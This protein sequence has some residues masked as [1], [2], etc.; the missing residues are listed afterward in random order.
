MGLDL[1]STA[2][3]GT[4]PPPPAQRRFFLNSLSTFF[5]DFPWEGRKVKGADAATLGNLNLPEKTTDPDLR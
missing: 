5:G 2:A 3:V 1:L 4:T